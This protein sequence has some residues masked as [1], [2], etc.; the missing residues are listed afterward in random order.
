MTSTS[1]YAVRNT[2]GTFDK[3][4][5]ILDAYSQLRISGITRSPTPEDLELALQRLED[6]A[7]SWSTTSE[8]GG[9]FFEEEPDPNSPSGIIRGYKQAYATNLAVKLI[10]DFNKPVPPTLMANASAELSNMVGR[11]A[12]ERIRQ[13]DYPS[14][15]PIGSGTANRYS[16]WARF[17]RNSGEIP[18][19]STSVTMFVGDTKDFTES[20][21]ANLFD[22]ETVDSY[23]LIVDSAL[24]VI[25]DSLSS[26]DITYRVRATAPA[27]D[28]ASNVQQITV[29]AVTSGGRTISRRRFVQIDPTGAE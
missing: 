8:D 19:S 9:Y 4:D 10:P 14:R 5:I 17:Y 25:S 13:V 29:I 3:V 27:G 11:I 12:A 26:P 1:L 23:T 2:G 21:G 18:L 28:K 7:A 16:R 24:T 20:Y 15:M 22:G 6:M